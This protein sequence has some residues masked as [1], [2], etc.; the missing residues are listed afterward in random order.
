MLPLL[1]EINKTHIESFKLW[2]FV[3]NL[4]KKICQGQA[5]QDYSPNCDCW[6]VQFHYHHRSHNR[7]ENP[8]RVNLK[9]QQ[10]EISAKKVK[11]TLT[12]WQLVNFGK[13]NMAVHVAKS[14]KDYEVSTNCQRVKLF[15][16]TSTTLNKRKWPSFS[17]Y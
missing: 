5:R 4:R 10:M 8:F 11:T 6:H 14:V 12:F 2:F 15:G 1:S 3:I 16:Y 9:V 13:N 17:H 7:Q